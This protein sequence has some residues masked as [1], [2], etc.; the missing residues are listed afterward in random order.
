MGIPARIDR[1]AA[2]PSRLAALSENVTP[3]RYNG[4]VL[5]TDL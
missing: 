5:A 1:K 2:W 4:N 3:W